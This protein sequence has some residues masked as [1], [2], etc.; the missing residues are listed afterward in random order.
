MSTKLKHQPSGAPES[1]NGGGSNV[2]PLSRCSAE[3]CSKKSEIMNFCNEHYA[4][5]KFGLVNK[6]GKRPSDFDKKYTAY[7]KKKA[8]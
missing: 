7:M 4:W 6:E 2:L 8:A 3:S 1:S 5:F